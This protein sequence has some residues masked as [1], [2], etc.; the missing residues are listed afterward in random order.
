MRVRLSLSMH[1]SDMLATK[2]RFSGISK[3]NNVFTTK[4]AQ[5]VII[6]SLDS[7]DIILGSHKV[8]STETIIAQTVSGCEGSSSFQLHSTHNQDV[9]HVHAGVRAMY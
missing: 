7:L 9:S 5:T 2:I 4:S 6:L 1:Y 3:T 8:N